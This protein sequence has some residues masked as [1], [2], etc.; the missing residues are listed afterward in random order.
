M[1]MQRYAHC[2]RVDDY[3]PQTFVLHE[4]SDPRGIDSQMK[5][6][7]MR[8]ETGMVLKSIDGSFAPL[9]THHAYADA[10]NHPPAQL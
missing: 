8:R 3:Y 2:L 5:A 6:A 10:K 1:K 9:V 7:G 4:S